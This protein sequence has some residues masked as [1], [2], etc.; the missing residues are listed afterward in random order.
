[1][2]D[3]K[4]RPGK[5]KFRSRT[6]YRP[7]RL[8]R[9]A[10]VVRAAV[11]AAR[12]VG[13]DPQLLVADGGLDASM[14]NPRGVPTITLGAGQHSP[15]TIDEWVDVREYLNGCRLALRVATR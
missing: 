9:K 6:D 14:L 13:L 5:I 8:D 15:H 1:M 11:E 2:R 12:E 10:P 3:H 4:G 7:F